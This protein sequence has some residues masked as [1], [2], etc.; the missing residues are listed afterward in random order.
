MLICCGSR[1]T[2]VYLF[3]PSSFFFYFEGLKDYLG[4]GKNKY[5]MDFKFG[6]D[7][8]C[9]NWFK[10]RFFLKKRKEEEVRSQRKGK[11]HGAQYDFF[12]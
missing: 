4:D 2:L 12:L 5:N 9:F 1:G 6:C 11:T 10:Y 3:A 8:F 7:N